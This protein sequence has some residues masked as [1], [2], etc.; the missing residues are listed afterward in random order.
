MN[1]LTRLL[2][3]S[4]ALQLIAT[5]ASAQQIR[6]AALDD[7][8]VYSVPVSAMRVT[9]VSFPSAISALDGAMITTDGKTPAVFQIAHTKGTAYFSARALAKDGVTNVNV[10]WNN[11]TYV[12][13]LRESSEPCFSFILKSG[14]E[15]A[16]KAK[17]PMT[18]NRLLGLLDKAKAFP[19][20][21]QYQP[22]AVRD[23][24]MRDLKAAPL[25]SDCGE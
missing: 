6:E 10:R 9:T 5:R 7:R 20:L 2:I 16:C 12:V 15:H 19:L 17:R 23:V 13:E 11:R 4:S 1:Q 21:Q 18:P 24:E 14:D 22:E 3:L 25:V 8:T